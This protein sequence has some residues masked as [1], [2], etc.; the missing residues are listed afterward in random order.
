MG[1]RLRFKPPAAAPGAVGG[2]GTKPPGGGRGGARAPPNSKLPGSIHFSSGCSSFL[3]CLQPFDSMKL[4]LIPIC[5]NFSGARG[6]SLYK[7]LISSNQFLTVLENSQRFY[8]IK[9][10]KLTL[11]PVCS[12]FVV[13]NLRTLPHSLLTERTVRCSEAEGAHRL[14][15]GSL[16]IIWKT[17]F[18]KLGRKL[19]VPIKNQ[20]DTILSSSLMQTTHA[21]RAVDDS[22]LIPET[23][24]SSTRPL[25]HAVEL[26]PCL[27]ISA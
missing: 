12:T 5:V 25:S 9:L 18:R 27:D 19:S 14:F 21:S 26:L 6:Q 8:S 3:R 10:K 16:Q 15:S 11:I 13:G 4:T 22:H 2:R 17:A 20:N 1:G 7:F 23:L 24:L